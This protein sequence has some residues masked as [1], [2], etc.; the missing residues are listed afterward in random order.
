M[1]ARQTLEEL[2]ELPVSLEIASD[3]LDRRPPIFRDDTCFFVSQSGETAD[4]MGALRYA[5]ACGALCVG[6]TNTVGSAID[7]ETDTGIHINAG[8]EIGVA[9]TKAYTSQIITLTL[10]ALSLCADS[11]A[12]RPYC[13]DLV[14]G[15]AAL[16][17]AVKRA[18]DLQDSI[19]VLA[20]DLKGEN[21][22]LVFG[23]G[24]NYATAMEA[25]LKVK[26]VSYMHSEGINA[27]EMKHGP[28]ALVDETLPIL[29]VAT[30]DAMHNKMQGV[31]QQLL[32]RKARLIIMINE[33][34]TETE[35]V[36]AFTSAQLVGFKGIPGVFQG[37]PGVVDACAWSPSM[38]CW[39]NCLCV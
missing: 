15:L 34:D 18:L 10:T 8:C 19:K 27:G 29:V 30:Q 6:I 22:L 25:A 1:A 2:A 31:I 21:S 20:E 28:L 12:K 9:S 4:T 37:I 24:R 23:R 36:C 35:A 13:N 5:K 14:N 3:M 33:G 32:A 17:A 11:I 39:K 7:R 38:Q 16:P 26:E